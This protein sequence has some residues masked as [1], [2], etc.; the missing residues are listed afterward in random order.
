MLTAG[1]GV[2]DT[3]INGR[4]RTRSSGLPPYYEVWAIS[5]A[6]ELLDISRYGLDD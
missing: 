1:V 3:M 4:L 6:L 2:R 5:G